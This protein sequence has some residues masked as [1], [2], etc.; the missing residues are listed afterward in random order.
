MPELCRYHDWWYDGPGIEKALRGAGIVV[1]ENNA[2][3]VQYRGKS[4]W[5]VGIAD[6]WTGNLTLRVPYIKS[7]AMTRCS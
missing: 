5:V 4:F 3:F 2:H 6:L 1:L 7:K